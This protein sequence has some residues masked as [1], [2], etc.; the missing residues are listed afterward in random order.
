MSKAEEYLEKHLIGAGNIP[1]QCHAYYAGDASESV[2]IA[3]KEMKEKAIEGFRHF[4]KDYSREAGHWDIYKGSDHY[5]E[6]FT[7]MLN[8]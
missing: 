7:E 1:S 2:D 3:E 4:V 5:I 6:W 8:K